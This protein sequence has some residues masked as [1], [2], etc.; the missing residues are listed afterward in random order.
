M[1]KQP[2]V[3]SY[4]LP[5]MLAARVSGLPEA[6]QVALAELVQKIGEAG[7]QRII[8]ALMLLRSYQL[9]ALVTLYGPAPASL[10]PSCCASNNNSANAK[11][12]S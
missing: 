12:A 9:R 8:N 7:F 6:D 2:T 3:V 11:T 10:F 4:R 5:A 1:T